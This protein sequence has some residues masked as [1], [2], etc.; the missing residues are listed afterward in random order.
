MVHDIGGRIESTGAKKCNAARK[1][2]SAFD[3]DKTEG[4]SGEYGPR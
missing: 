1:R 4:R 2:S 3:D